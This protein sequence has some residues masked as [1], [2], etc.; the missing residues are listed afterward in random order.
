MR[1]LAAALGTDDLS[2][3]V[4]QPRNVRV[5]GAKLATLRGEGMLHSA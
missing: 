3:G 5:I 1:G 4:N 2:L